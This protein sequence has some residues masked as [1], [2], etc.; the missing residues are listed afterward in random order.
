MPAYDDDGNRIA[1]PGYIDIIV[2]RGGDE[3]RTEV[4]EG[5]TINFLIQEGHLR[6]VAVANTRLNN[7][8]ANGDDTVLP[9]DTVVQIPRSGKQG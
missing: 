7:A 6:G 3:V 4:P 5:S 1:R 9:G 2:Q 8:P